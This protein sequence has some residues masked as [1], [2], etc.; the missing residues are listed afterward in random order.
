MQAM[1][2]RQ[3]HMDFHTSEWI[4]EVGALFDPEVFAE[5]LAKAHVDSVTCF[6][7]CHHGWLY[8]D[9]KNMPALK[10][11][12]LQRKNLLKDQVVACHKRNIKVPIYTTVQ[13]DGRVA[14]AHPEWLA[15]DEAGQP[16]NS[17]GVEEPHFYY[18]LC[19]NSG[20]REF[21]KA[22]LEDIVVS[23]GKDYIDGFFMDILFKTDCHCEKCMQD[24]A[25][26]GYDVHSKASRL[27]YSQWMI[28]DFKEEITAWIQKEVPQGSIFY[29]SSHIGP[30]NKKSLSNYTHLELESLP[31]GGWGYDY[32][33]VTVRYA[34]LL[35]KDLVGMTGKFHTYWGDFHSLKNKAALEFE[36]FQMLSLGAGC[37]I[38]DQMHPRG[39]LSPGAYAEIGEVYG[40]VA[41][42]EPYCRGAVPVAEIGVLT[43]EEFAHLRP[44]AGN[45][46]E[47]IIGVVHML[48]E[49]AYQFNIIDSQ[50]RFEDYKVLILPD[51]IDYSEAL[52]AKLEAY[53]QVGG[54]VLGSYGSMVDPS[55]LYQRFYGMKWTGDSSFDR[56]FVMPNQR[57]GKAL[58]QEPYVMYMRGMAVEAVEAEVLMDS[59]EPYFNREGEKF[60]SH[61]HAP[62]SQKIGEPAVLMGYNS[63]YFAHPIF[64]LYR[65]NAAL[66]CKEMVKDA[67][68]ILMPQRLIWHDGPSTLMVN[69][70]QQGAH[71]RYVVHLLHYITEK[72]SKDIFTIEDCVGLY[73]Q[74][75]GCYLEGKQV[76]QVVLLPSGEP[77]DF[78]QDQEVLSVVVPEIKG[79]QVIG[80]EYKEMR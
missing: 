67:L 32:F 24:M 22:H 34:R 7:R 45:I 9:S 11:P 23:L 3:V 79:Y 19:L 16:I 10:H 59:I 30:Y 61:Q 50:S 64:R 70:S 8:Y 4:S 38:G 42:L 43:P 75:I 12:E 13:W 18:T 47:E 53:R 65:K 37:S 15:I 5:T 77:L 78:D 46:S 73:G 36:C 35:G 40:R 33:P 39:V 68:A 44:E 27:A 62:A 41:D 25:Q 66:W 54:K 63:I 6:A 55:K 58:W 72:R 60:C 26:R 1:R 48:Q 57:M 49:L 74:K 71:N 14:K 2:Y 17:Q 28:D 69:L 20:Y 31:S 80:I 56:N 52:E 76:E 29:N 21:F 51:S